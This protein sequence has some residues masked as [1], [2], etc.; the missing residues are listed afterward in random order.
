MSNALNAGM[1]GKLGTLGYGAYHMVAPGT[2]LPSNGYIV[3]SWQGGGLTPDHDLISGLEWVRAYA[4]SARMAGSIYTAFDG[5][6]NGGTLAV[7]GYANIG[8]RREDEIELVETPP[9]GEP[10]YAVGALYRII[11][12]V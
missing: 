9:D 3:W 7:S 10:V 8:L 6:L 5:V 2:V 12:D 4:T 1:Y 11:L